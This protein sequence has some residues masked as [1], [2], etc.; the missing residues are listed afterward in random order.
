MTKLVC[1]RLEEEASDIVP[2]RAER[3][4]MDL[5]DERFAYRCLPLTIANSMGWEILCPTGI[6]AEW[7]GE[8]GLDAITVTTGD[9]GS[10]EGIAS[11]HFG[12]GVLTFHVR[13]LF[14]TDPGF[15]LWV[16]GVPNLPKDGIAPLEGIV[17]T[18]WLAFTFTMNWQFTRP[19]LVRFA[20]GEPFCFVT[21]VEYRALDDVVPEVVALDDAPEL[22]DTFRDYSRLRQEF[23]ERLRE[24]DPETVRAGW[25][26]WYFRG[27]T[28]SG[29]TGNP[30]HLS[31]LRV[32]APRNR[33]AAAPRDPDV[34]SGT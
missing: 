4:W 16:R 13:Y 14:R 27:K 9:G 12:H 15:G 32:A 25:Q 1:Y 34:T 33:P 28:P 26:K 8:M 19:G 30:R 24:G 3:D 20:Q 18:D 29:E 11:S 23:N 7:N 6:V 21:P 10:A 17:E 31:K 22:R 2:G 5:T